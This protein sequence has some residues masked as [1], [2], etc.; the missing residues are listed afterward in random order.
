M[1]LKIWSAS[2]L[3]ADGWAEDVEIT[4]EP[5]GDI[6][7]VSSSVAWQ[8]GERVGVMIPGIPNVHSHA[9]QRAMSGLGERAGLSGESAKD[10][11][12]TWRK[13]MYHYL[14]R[15]QPGHLHHIAAQLYLE[16]L[17]SG[18]TCVGEF[19]YLHHDVDGK[20]YDNRAARQDAAR[21]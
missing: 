16:M 19:Q 18:Y 15:I 20:A 1:A 7:K 5:G 10:S 13:V 11:F 12:W 14:E 8:D 21:L 6:S 4:V 17:K 3:L 9:H 2:A